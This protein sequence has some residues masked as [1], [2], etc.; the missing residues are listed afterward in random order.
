[1][2]EVPWQIKPRLSQSYS[3]QDSSL[4]RS[5]HDLE[6]F[7]RSLSVDNPAASIHSICQHN[8]NAFFI[9]RSHILFASSSVFGRTVRYFK[10]QRYCRDKYHHKTSLES[11]HTI[12]CA[13]TASHSYNALDVKPKSINQI[14]MK[15]A[16]WP[17]LEQSALKKVSM[18]AAHM[19]APNAHHTG[20]EKLSKD[21]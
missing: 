15:A 12:G 8:Y 11:T 2:P 14:D 10:S 13:H 9:F 4:S 21:L 17:E 19:F 20:L 6:S 16:A 3:H 18:I 7:S 5:G 1:M